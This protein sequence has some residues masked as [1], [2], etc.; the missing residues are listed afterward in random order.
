MSEVKRLVRYLK[1]LEQELKTLL[2]TLETFNSAY[3]EDKNNRFEM[4]L[5]IISLNV[6][7]EV[8][9]EFLLTNQKYFLPEVFSHAWAILHSLQ[10]KVQKNLD[11]LDAGFK[12]EVEGFSREIEELKA[13][14]LR[15]KVE[16]E[17]YDS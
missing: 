15:S 4:K 16:D 3:L 12:P 17:T 2:Q 10:E 7:S 14:L 5:D 1:G 8:L 11:L 9:R 13:I 6:T